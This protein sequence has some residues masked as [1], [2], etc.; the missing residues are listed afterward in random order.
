MRFAV[1]IGTLASTPK[2][3]AILFRLLATG[4]SYLGLSTHGLLGTLKTKTT[5][6]L[7]IQAIGSWAEVPQLRYLRSSIWSLVPWRPSQN[8]PQSYNSCLMAAGLRH[9][10]LGTL[11]GG[12]AKT[13]GNLGIHAIG[14]RA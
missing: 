5:G 10:G 9:M 3:L 4:L 11:L 13:G 2:R 6:D 7:A 1:G 12:K 8:G 14:R